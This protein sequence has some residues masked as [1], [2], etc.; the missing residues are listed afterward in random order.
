VREIINGTNLKL[1]S[2]SIFFS[3]LLLPLFVL[4]E[5]IQNRLSILD[6]LLSTETSSRILEECATYLNKIVTNNESLHT[7]KDFQYLKKAITVES[8]LDALIILYDE[9]SNSTL[10]REKTVSDF[11]ELCT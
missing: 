4:A 8:L 9:C 6:G 1:S 11:L 3:S 2:L 10:R 7:I 5:T